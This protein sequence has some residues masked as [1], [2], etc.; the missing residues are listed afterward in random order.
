MRRTVSRASLD[1]AA[2]ELAADAEDAETIAGTLRV[3]FPGALSSDL[4]R[5][6]DSAIAAHRRAILHAGAGASL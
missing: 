4:I 3:T 6:A 2:R 1:R 5:A